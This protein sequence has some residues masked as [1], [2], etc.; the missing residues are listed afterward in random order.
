MSCS[1]VELE[2]VEP[3]VDS[4]PCEKI[5]VPSLLHDPAAVEDHNPVGIPYGGKAVGDDEGGPSLHGPVHGLLDLSLH[6][7]VQ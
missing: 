2:V 4:A 1:P 6:L 5:L 3:A 7:E